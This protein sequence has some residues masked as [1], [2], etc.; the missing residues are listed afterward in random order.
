MPGLNLNMGLGGSGGY[1]GPVF[2]SDGGAAAVPA[3]GGYPDTGAGR[4]MTF[5]PGSA[6]SGAAGHPTVHAL[7]F[8]VLCFAA[9]VF[10]AWA[11]PR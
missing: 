3:S 5:G 2:G 8:G 11:L 6:G 9:L 10:M 7:S 4:A 1:S